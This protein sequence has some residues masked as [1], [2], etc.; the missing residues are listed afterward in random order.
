LQLAREERSA[1]LRENLG[2]IA[3]VLEQAARAEQA[4]TVSEGASGVLEELLASYKIED[5]QRQLARMHPEPAP[6]NTGQP[7]RSVTVWGPVKSA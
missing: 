3:A 6:E 2:R 5:D 7:A 4:A 1:Y